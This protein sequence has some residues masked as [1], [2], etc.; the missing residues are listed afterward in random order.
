MK[1]GFVIIVSLLLFGCASSSKD[2][3]VLITPQ[4]VSVAEY[5]DFLQQLDT[6]IAEGVPRQLNPDEKRHYASLSASLK[7]ML[8]DHDSLDTLAPADVKQVALMHERLQAVV[9]G[10]EASK[11]IC[12]SER[13]T[14]TNF[15]RT[16]CIT[17]AEWEQQ[18]RDMENFF[19]QGHGFASGMS[20]PA[21]G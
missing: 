17:R 2:T 16:T 19:R 4:T 7:S 10:Q 5:K 14:G 11:I 8:A 15:K 12:R 3:R 13:S 9:V 20:G 18:Q 21:G 6:A 1:Y